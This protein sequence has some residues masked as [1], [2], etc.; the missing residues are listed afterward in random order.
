MD[1][2]DKGTIQVLARME[3]DI[4]RFHPTAQNS[5]KVDPRDSI[6]LTRNSMKLDMPDFIILLTKA[7]SWMCKISSRYSA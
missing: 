6:T 2:L 1:R 4:A 7:G 3:L 5:R